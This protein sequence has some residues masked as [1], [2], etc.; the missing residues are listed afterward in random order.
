MVPASRGRGR[1]GM[2]HSNSE[3]GVVLILVLS[4]IAILVVVAVE[5]FRMARID[6]RNSYYMHDELKARAMAKSGLVIGRLLL[7][8]GPEEDEADHHGQPWGQGLG[9]RD[10]LLPDLP[11]DEL[12]LL[13]I[14][15][16]G[17]FPINFI[18][19]GPVASKT[20]EKTEQ[21]E[22]VQ[23]GQAEKPKRTSGQ[24]D[25]YFRIFN[26]MLTQGPFNLALDE[27]EELAGYVREWVAHDPELEDGVKAADVYYLDSEKSY[28]SKNGP[29]SSVGEL[30][31]IRGITP[32]IYAGTKESPGLKDLVTVH[33][34]QGK[35]NINTAPE[36]VLQAMVNP[37]IDASTAARFA[38]DMINYREDSFHWDYLNEKDW[39]R[40]RMAGYNDVQL[41][42]DIVATNSAVF[43]IKSC[44]FYG[45]GRSCVADYVKREAGSE[46][47]KNFILNSLYREMY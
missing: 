36:S 7:K 43:K 18:V 5:S 12:E 3:S 25:V 11:E 40:N 44:G 46:G 17:K 2:H 24:P 1:T 23:E 45:H 34:P 27:A 6:T 42:S 14:D 20:Q 31:L 15:E 9:Q 4:L 41:P 10:I 32:E 13:I 37:S 35:I 47:D 30:L 16:T 22:G 26:R 8:Q 28:K 29:L 33:S 39:Y 38:I 19:Q 21:K